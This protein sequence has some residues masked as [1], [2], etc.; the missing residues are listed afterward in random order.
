MFHISMLRKYVVNSDHVVQFFDFEFN[1]N[2]MYEELSVNIVDFKE[3]E[4]RKHVI[5]Y[6]KFQWI[7]HSKCEATRSWSLK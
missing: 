6:V 3:Q 1:S 5:P 2:I 7:N 4:L